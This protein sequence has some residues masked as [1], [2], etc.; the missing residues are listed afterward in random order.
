[1]TPDAFAG[2]LQSAGIDLGPEDPDQLGEAL[3]GSPACGE[4][5]GGCVTAPAHLA[6]TRWIT[7]IDDAG[8]PALSEFTE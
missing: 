2:E 1:V 3:D 5:G 6:C 8:A 4:V 7:A